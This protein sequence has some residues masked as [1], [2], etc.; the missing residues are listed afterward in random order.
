MRFVAD[1]LLWSA[2][3]GVVLC[4]PLVIRAI[5][6]ELLHHDDPRFR[7]TSLF[8]RLVRRWRRDDAR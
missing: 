6:T 4:I 1:F 2:I 3:I 7:P 5:R 8:G